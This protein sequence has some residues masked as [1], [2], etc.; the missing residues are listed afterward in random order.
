MSSPA[1]HVRK[2]GWIVGTI[3]EGDPII[4]DGKLIEEGRVIQITA[5][6]EH[7]V[8]AKRIDK[9]WPESSWGFTSRNWKVKEDHAEH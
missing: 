2:M 8:L 1:N 4:R 9:R 5:I 6:G 7:S 3:L